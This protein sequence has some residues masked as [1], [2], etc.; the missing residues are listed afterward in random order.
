MH[1]TNNIRFEC[2]LDENNG[3]KYK[4][5]R[6][7]GGVLKKKSQSGET[8]LAGEKFASFDW[9]PRGLHLLCT[10]SSFSSALAKN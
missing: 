7:I 9:V 10:L 2:C 1:E 5:F 8:G 3:I 4:V 6:N